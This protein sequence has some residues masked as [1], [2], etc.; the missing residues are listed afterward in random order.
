MRS[1]GRGF[2]SPAN[3]PAR[4]PVSF[5]V[6]RV[7]RVECSAPPPPQCLIVPGG[8]SWR[9]DC[10]GPRRPTER[11]RRETTKM[12]SSFHRMRGSRT[13][14][15]PQTPQTRSV[16]SVDRELRGYHTARPASAA[17][18]RDR[19]QSLPQQENIWLPHLTLSCLRETR[20]AKPYR[21]FVDL[22][23]AH[24]PEI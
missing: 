11:R 12:D 2:G 22:R 21:A 24:K 4:A 10:C 13:P 9:G 8:W 19:R 23:A 1:A 6:G 7:T 5:Y 18:S 14:P 15:P 16:R 20:E 3:P 17:G